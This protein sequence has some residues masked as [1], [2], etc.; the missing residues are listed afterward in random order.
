MA[1]K[2]LGVVRERERERKWDETDK[3]MEG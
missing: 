2:Q 3:V 1:K